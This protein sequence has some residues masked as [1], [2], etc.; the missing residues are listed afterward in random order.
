MKTILMMMIML[1]CCEM[2]FFAG[3]GIGINVL[4]HFPLVLIHILGVS[5]KVWGKK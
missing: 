1:K 5:D 3:G 4:D 2:S